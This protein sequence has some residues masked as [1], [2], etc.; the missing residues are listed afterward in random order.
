MI[1]PKYETWAVSGIDGQIRSLGYSQV[2]N[3]HDFNITINKNQIFVNSF[4][5]FN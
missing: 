4:S 1:L 3:A 2:P 5:C